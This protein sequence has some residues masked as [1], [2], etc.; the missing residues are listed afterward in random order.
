MT[1]ESEIELIAVY[2]TGLALLTSD[3]VEFVAPAKEFEIPENFPITK[4]PVKPGNLKEGYD[5]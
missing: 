3:G 4:Q 1:E 2:D 5:Y